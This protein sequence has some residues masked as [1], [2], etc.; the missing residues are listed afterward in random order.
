MARLKTLFRRPAPILALKLHVK[1]YLFLLLA[2][3]CAFPPVWLCYAVFMQ[4]KTTFM[5]KTTMKLSKAIRNKPPAK[6]IKQLGSMKM[7]KT[8]LKSVETSKEAAPILTPALL[9]RL[10]ATRETGKS[11]YWDLYVPGLTFKVSCP[12]FTLKEHNSFAAELAHLMNWAYEKGQENLKDDLRR[13]FH[14]FRSFF[15]S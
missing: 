9:K 3:F 6:S 4:S 1:G 8:K 11:R 5:R 15:N 10:G 13:Q 12:R 2:Y 14:L 7:K